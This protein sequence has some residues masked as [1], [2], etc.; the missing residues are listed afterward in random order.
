MATASSAQGDDKYVTLSE[1]H[2]RA[3][4]SARHLI[5]SG[6]DFSG[7]HSFC[8]EDFVDKAKKTSL[9]GGQCWSPLLVNWGSG[10]RKLEVAV[11]VWL[12]L[13]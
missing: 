13:L 5:V 1:N 6:M 11:G 3:K 2:K 9:E 12:D 8:I 10:S 4:T 7:K